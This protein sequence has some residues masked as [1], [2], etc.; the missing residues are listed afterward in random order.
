MGAT[1]SSPDSVPAV[2]L[3]SAP[4]A[5]PVLTAAAAS[6][7]ESKAEAPP[8]RQDHECK[9][10]SSCALKWAPQDVVS[11]TAAPEGAAVIYAAAPLWTITDM[12]GSVGGAV[13]AS[14]EAITHGVFTYGPRAVSTSVTLE[15]PS[16]AE[17]VAFLEASGISEVEGS[18][19]CFTVVNQT[20]ARVFIETTA[21]AEHWTLYTSSMANYVDFVRSV[22]YRYVIGAD[23]MSATLYG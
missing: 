7:V 20:N 1:A 4:E 15:L 14:P 22:T 16:V 2:A 21:D 13:A 11:V 18:S 8:C 5:L 17:L 3:V 9:V 10:C 19:G 12:S 6:A 23:K